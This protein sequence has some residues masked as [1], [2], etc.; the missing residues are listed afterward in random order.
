MFENFEKTGGDADSRRRADE[1]RAAEMARLTAQGAD[2]EVRD[3][4]DGID[5][6]LRTEAVDADAALV[7][8]DR[9]LDAH[10]GSEAM[11]IDELED[12]IEEHGGEDE[13]VVLEAFEDL[14]ERHPKEFM[15]HVKLGAVR[16]FLARLITDNEEVVNG[17]VSEA[18]EGEEGTLE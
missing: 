2:E 15:D 8:L 5:A 7:L 12:A 10:P 16:E 1:A 14:K 9:Y 3:E 17:P 11:T 13:A 4:L 6:A 18:P